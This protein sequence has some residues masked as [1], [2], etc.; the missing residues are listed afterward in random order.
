[1]VEPRPAPAGG[2][3]DYT[4]VLHRA[5][6]GTG[7]AVNGAS[8]VHCDASPG[9]RVRLRLI[10]AVPPGNK[11]TPQAPV[12]LGAPY[13]VDALDG[14]DLNQPQLL[15]PELV[16][17][18]MGQ[19]ADLVFT[20]PASGAVRL[21]LASL[22]VLQAS[23]PAASLAASP[24]V[25][26]GTGQAPVPAGL[27]PLPVFDP[28]VYGHPAPDPLRARTSFDVTYHVTLTE[29]A[30]FMD[31][32]GGLF[33]LINGKVPPDMAQ[34][35]VREGQAVEMHLDNQTGEWHPMHLHGHVFLL[36][37]VDGRPATGA[38][39][40]QD[41]VL[42][43]PHQTADVAFL[44]NNPGLWMFHCHVLMHASM[45]MSGMVVYAG[46]TTPY[47]MGPGTG[48]TPE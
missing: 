42:V 6:D 25:T 33:H 18:G 35:V 36:L 39:V 30:G 23:R 27:S 17:L 29:R 10:N 40:Y 1:V 11:G 9:D 31:G 46:V 12:L 43:A 21:A 44:A 48:N 5:L 7:V 24:T 16:P 37:A 26:I 28:L 4:L 38:P 13:Q 32:R 14:H 15:G 34:F 41:S 3:R 19:R 45:G 2:T 20:M 22:P 8:E 47:R